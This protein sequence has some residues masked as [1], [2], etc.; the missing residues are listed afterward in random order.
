M[1]ERN[2]RMQEEMVRYQIERRGISDERVLEAMRTVPRH[3]FIPDAEMDDA[4][5]DFPL[6]I[7]HS[8]TISQ[9]FIVAYMCELARFRKS[10][11]VLEVGTGSGYHA[12]VI[13]R[14]A[15]SVY[16]VEIVPELAVH[17]ANTVREL[18]YTNIS[19]RHGDGFYGWAEAS[20]FDVIVVTAA[21]DAIPPP[22]V[23][24]LAEGGRLIIP[25]GPLSSTQYLVLAEKR[26]G[27]IVVREM[28]PVRFVPLTG[29]H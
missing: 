2:E 25:L 23:S 6:P 11:R 3:R 17:A 27:E 8:Q 29:K 19:I 12:S 22:L 18:N 24:Q 5:G 7:G 13:A 20:P 14:L 21:T 10:D 9:P 4:Y 15:D 26:A 28:L 16:S 1:T